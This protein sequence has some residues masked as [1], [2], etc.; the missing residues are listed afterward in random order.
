MI[1]KDKVPLV[2]KDS[3]NEMHFEEIDI[4]NTLW[5]F[6]EKEDI[7]AITKQMQVLIA[8]MQVHFTSEEDMM[9][10]Q[11]YPMYTIH[12]SDHNKVLSEARYMFMDWRNTKD[13]DRI[14]EYCEDELLIW[15]DQHIK[16]M[17]M[18]LADFLESKN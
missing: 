2:S 12:Q 11:S 7:D 3:M 17:D 8:H 9:K 5:E 1:D 4:I 10:G 14:R 16:A 15:L 18:P 13:L 6:I